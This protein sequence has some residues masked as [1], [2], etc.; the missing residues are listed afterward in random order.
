MVWNSNP[1]VNKQ[2]TSSTL[3]GKKQKHHQNFLA[4]KPHHKSR[5]NKQI[6]WITTVEWVV[7]LVCDYWIFLNKQIA[8]NGISSINQ[9]C[10]L[11]PMKYYLFWWTMNKKFINNIRWNHHK[12]GNYLIYLRDFSTNLF[13]IN[14]L[15]FAWVAKLNWEMF[16]NDVLQKWFSMFFCHRT[17]IQFSLWIVT[18][19]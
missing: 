9:K 18:L 13:S 6:N 10:T 14:W 8:V 15:K 4:N 17:S 11:I 7:F 2:D 16:T 1:N 5:P 12:N 3:R 19:L